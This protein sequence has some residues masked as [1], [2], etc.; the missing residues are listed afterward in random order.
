M[1]P[2]GPA[3]HALNHLLGQAEWARDRLRPFAGRHARIISPLLALAFTLREDGTVVASE[4]DAVADVEVVLPIPT[5]ADLL[6]GRA[7]VFS[8]ARINGAA[9]LAEALGFVLR[10]LDWDAEEDLSRVVGDIAARRMTA[11]ARSLADWG[12]Q[13]AA[14]LAGN[15]TE[16]LTEENPALVK[17]AEM[18]ALARQI[19]ELSDR[20][21]QLEQRLK[22]LDA[23]SRR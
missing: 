3:I 16:Y 4:R 8:R 14:N 10:N 6:A 9:D 20:L 22:Q 11:G 18:P 5:P 15:V 23:G 12:R 21:A 19:D 13:A 2:S 7:G 17:A 1:L